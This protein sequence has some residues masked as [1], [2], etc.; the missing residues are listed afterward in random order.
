MGEPV[1]SFFCQSGTEAVEGAETGALRQWTF[2][3]YWLSRRFHGRT[4][5]RW[6][7]RP[8]KHAAE[9]L[10]IRLRGRDP[11]A[12]PNPYRRCSPATTRA[13]RFSITLK[14]HCLSAMPA[15]EVAAIL[16]EPIQGEGGYGAA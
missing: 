6:L 12:Y 16:V 5:V 9:R 2:A 3:L 7:S 14:T 1:L 15:S 4:M 13:R 11:F 10:F 8:V